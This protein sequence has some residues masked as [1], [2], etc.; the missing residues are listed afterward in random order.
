MAIKSAYLDFEGKH[1]DE[2]Y[3]HLLIRKS[4]ISGKVRIVNLKES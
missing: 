1:D 2:I 3:L 4:L